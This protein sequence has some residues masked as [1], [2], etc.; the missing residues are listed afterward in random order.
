[1]Q[2]SGGQLCE[3]ADRENLIVVF[4]QG[5]FTIADENLYK[6]GGPARR[7]GEPQELGRKSERV[8]IHERLYPQGKGR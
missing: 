7:S 4:P 2:V 1:M 6:H 8:Y 3:L 5:S